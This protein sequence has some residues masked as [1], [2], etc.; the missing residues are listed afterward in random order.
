MPVSLLH[1]GLFAIGL[2]C[3]SIPIILHLLKRR[4]RVVTW[5]A[6]RFLEEAYRKRRRIITIEQ[7]ILLTLRCLL[8]ALIALGVG[9]LMLGSGNSGSLPTTLFIVLD[10][11]IGSATSAN[12][13]STLDQSKRMVTEAIE[14]L[15]P[16]RGDRVALVSASSPARGLVIPPSND[17]AAVLSMVEQAQPS[18]AGLDLQGALALVGDLDEPTEAGAMRRVLLLASANR[19]LERAMGMI[20]ETQARL[21][22]DE[23]LLMPSDDRPV[24]NVG[25]L[26][27]R[28]TRSLIVRDGLA[29]PEAVRIELARSGDQ[30]PEQTSTIR[31]LDANDQQ[32]GQGRV[33]WQPGQREA[34][35]SVVL[36]TRSLSAHAGLSSIVRVRLDDDANPRDNTGLLALPVRN[37][38]RVGVLDRPSPRGLGSPAGIAPA[39]WVRA[40]LAPSDD[41][42]V[43]VTSIDA[44]QA[45]TRLTASFDALVIVAPAAISPEGWER[46]A[47]LREQGTMLIVTPDAQNES[48][49]WFEQLRELTPETFEAGERFITHEPSL[50]IDDRVDSASLLSGIAGEL[51]TLAG[52]V[53]V[54]RSLQLPAGATPI[55]SL[56]DGS[57][58]GVQISP[59]DGAGTIVVL[60]TPLDLNWSNLPARPVFVALM[61]ELVRQG[62]GVG[63]TLPPILAG[64]PMPRPLWAQSIQPIELP[65]RNPDADRLHEPN[66]VA[67]VLALRDAQG[68]VRAL[69]VVQPDSAGAIANPVERE[70]VEANLARFIDASSVQWAGQDQA[71]NAAGTTQVSSSDPRSLALNLLWAALAVATIEFILARLFTVRLV[72]REQVMGTMSGGGTRHE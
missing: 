46:V 22:F 65:G 16:A 45:A 62:V 4:R 17:L 47:R 19:S 8:I 11:G 60:A 2:A 34:S 68:S 21:A 52:A 44:Q 25:I 41:M 13:E 38:L 50:G 33:Q 10:D 63:S 20:E 43:R 15:D 71:N 37:S 51:P 72:A 36:E 69:Q 6:M 31:I 30:L 66:Q 64:Q 67:G 14:A 40:A 56:S 1:P 39:R 3:V 35:T 61:Q 18:D 27:V 32:R 5:G 9:S 12:G 59:R 49:A 58:L 28:P 48:L 24:T 55:A 23:L 7:L 29:L 57:A 42:G 70:G 26:A 54:H 53:E